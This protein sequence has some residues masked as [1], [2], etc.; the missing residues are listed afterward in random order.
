MH[1]FPSDVLRRKNDFRNT[2][3]H[4]AAKHNAKSLEHFIKVFEADMLDIKNEFC[5]TAVH[6]AAQRNIESLALLID[7]FVE[8]VLSVKNH[9]G[10]TTL[11]VAVSYNTYSTTFLLRKFTEKASK[12]LQKEWF[13]VENN[14]YQ[15]TIRLA[16]PIVSSQK[17]LASSIEALLASK[18]NYLN[19][20]I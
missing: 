1:E 14:N 8:K 17:P 6:I 19:I 13:Y 7:K 15:A 9:D 16:I 2:A 20:A 4:W 3:L 5:E 12:I 10:E 11:Q 18:N